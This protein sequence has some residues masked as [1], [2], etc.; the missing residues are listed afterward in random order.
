MGEHINQDPFS[1]KDAPVENQ[2]PMRVIL[3]GAGFSGIYTTIRISQRL[4]NVQLQV[5][6]QN[7]ELA[8]VWWLNRYPGLACD[9]PSYSYQFS[10]APNPYWSSLY[11]PGPEIRAYMQDVAERYGATRYIKTSHAVKECAWDAGQKI[12]RVKIHNIK[13]GEVF[14]DTAN[15]VISAKGGLNQIMWPRIKGLGDYRGKLIHSGEWD[16]RQATETE[17]HDPNR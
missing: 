2:R 4:R 9:I 11:A 15:V 10:F 8:G 1:I 6:E 3:I 16:E 12:W 17:R 5:Y 14:E 7:E 13:T